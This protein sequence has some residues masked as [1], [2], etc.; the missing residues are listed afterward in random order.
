[1]CMRDRQN[2]IVRLENQCCWDYIFLGCSKIERQFK[3]TSNACERK[4]TKMSRYWN[5]TILLT[6]LWFYQMQKIHILWAVRCVPAHLNVNKFFNSHNTSNGHHTICILYTVE[7]TWKYF[8]KQI[9]ILHVWMLLSFVVLIGP[10]NNNMN[11]DKIT[12]NYTKLL[13]IL[14]Q[15][16]RVSHKA[17]TMH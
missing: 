10:S 2:G 14:C 1:M 6:I 4:K 16:N 3:T 17:H 13:V 9:S 5:I 11:V 7:Q 8:S 15:I 12:Q